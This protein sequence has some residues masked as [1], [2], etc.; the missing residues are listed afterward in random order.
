MAT[1][2]IPMPLAPKSGKRQQNT[3]NYS[4]INCERKGTKD[5]LNWIFLSIKTMAK[6]TLGN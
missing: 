4:E 5:I 6:F 3:R 2:F 1:K